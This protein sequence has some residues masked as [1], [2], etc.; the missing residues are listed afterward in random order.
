VYWAKKGKIAA[1]P[2]EDVVAGVAS[3]SMAMESIREENLP[4]DM[5]G[6]SKDELKKDLEQ[7]AKKRSEAQKQIADLAKQR[8]EYLKANTKAADDGFDSVV[9]K[10]LVE[11]LAK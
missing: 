5:R 3:G 7:R 11:Q 9:K 1:K 4:A 8:D 10:T 6:M 2:A